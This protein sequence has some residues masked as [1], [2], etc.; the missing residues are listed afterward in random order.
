MGAEGDELLLVFPPLAA[1]YLL[2]DNSKWN[3]GVKSYNESYQKFAII[4]IQILIQSSV[5]QNRHQCG[6]L[7]NYSFIKNVP[8][9]IISQ[10]Q[11][12]YQGGTLSK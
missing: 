11:S 7:P 9:N 10:P 6:H 8:L 3:E 12:S 2:R 4:Q 1:L 5:F